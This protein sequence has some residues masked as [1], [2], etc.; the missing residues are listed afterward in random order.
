MSKCKKKCMSIII[1]LLLYL[2]IYNPPLLKFN[3]AIVFCIVFTAFFIFNYDKIK[4]YVDC[5]KVLI[6]EL[7]FGIELVFFCIISFLN[8]NSLITFAYLFY[9][10]FCDIMFAVFVTYIFKKYGFSFIWLLNVIIFSTA[11]FSLTAILAFLSP[12]IKGFFDSKLIAYGA[13]HADILTTYRDYGFAANLTNTSSFVTAAVS[14]LC[15]YLGA[16]YKKRY[17]LFVPFF[18][19]AAFINARTSIV[20]LV[21]G[22]LISFLCISRRNIVKIIL[23]F[24]FLVVLGIL[25]LPN[26]LE[27]ISD[28]NVETANWFNSGIQELLSIFTKSDNDSD[29]YVSYITNIERWILP[30]DFGFL[31]GKGTEIQG[32]SKYGVYSDIGFVNDFWRGG[33]VLFFINSITLCCIIRTFYKTKLIDFHG[34]KFAVLFIIFLCMIVNLKGSFFIHNDVSI[35]IILLTIAIYTSKSNKKVI[36]YDFKYHLQSCQH[37]STGLQC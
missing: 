6:I 2:L 5:K 4:K 10:I 37:Y 35:V 27:L 22:I 21:L 7:L 12:T 20:I 25:V 33:L 19:F 11:L 16:N 18:A 34:R 1:A 13:E 31:F 32:G 30:S 17:L 9:W 8:N 15:F 28:K 26:V 14:V 24:I 23:L 29:S 36:N 3:F